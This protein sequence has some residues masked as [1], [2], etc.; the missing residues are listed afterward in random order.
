MRLAFLAPLVLLSAC[1]ISVPQIEDPFDEPG[2]SLRVDPDVVERGVSEVEITDDRREIDFRTVWD[3][4]DIGDF[5]VTEWSSNQD[6]LRVTIDV[7]DSAEGT[8]QLLIL[9]EDDEDLTVEFD[10]R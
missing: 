2:S 3:V 9:L 10:V 1:I 7:I 8:Q 5:V 6:R 4:D